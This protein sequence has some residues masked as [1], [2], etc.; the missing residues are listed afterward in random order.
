MKQQNNVFLWIVQLVKLEA[1]ANRIPLDRKEPSGLTIRHM[2]N[3]IA[4][5]L[6]HLS[7]GLFS[8]GAE[9]LRLVIVYISIIVRYLHRKTRDIVSNYPN[10]C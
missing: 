6:I 1:E 3:K 10:T 9:N 4:L 2:T 5:V 7:G 8:S